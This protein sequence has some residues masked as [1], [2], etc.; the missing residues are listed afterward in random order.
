MAGFLAAGVANAVTNVARQAL[1]RTRTPEHLRGRVFAA[2]DSALRTAM[3]V[4]T[5]L[6]GVVVLN[7]GPRLS[8]TIAGSATIVA[9]LA[10]VLTTREREP[11]RV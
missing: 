6:G 8:M 3:V 4:G 9:G 7:L 10:M 1:V 11:A 2:A 5:L